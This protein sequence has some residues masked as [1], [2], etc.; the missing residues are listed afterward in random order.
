LPFRETLKKKRGRDMGQGRNDSSGGKIGE[1]GSHWKVKIQ[2]KR[3][4]F[5]FG[6]RKGGSYSVIEPTNGLER[7][8]KLGACIWSSR[9]QAK[10]PRVDNQ[11]TCAVKGA[12]NLFEQAGR[13]TEICE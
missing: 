1:I 5:R 10:K 13:S 11:G 8:G 9:E 12:G 4:L 2:S 6:Q 3:L 7:C